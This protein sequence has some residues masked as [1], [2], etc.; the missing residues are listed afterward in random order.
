VIKLTE[1]RNDPRSSFS[2]ATLNRW[3]NTLTN[4]DRVIARTAIDDARAAGG[5][6]P[7]LVAAEVLFALG[8]A[9]KSAGLNSA[10]IQLYKNAWKAAHLSLGHICDGGDEDDDD[11]DDDDDD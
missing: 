3:I 11:D 8:D 10:A 4:A 1:L 9:A 7:H 2:D 6:H 5:P